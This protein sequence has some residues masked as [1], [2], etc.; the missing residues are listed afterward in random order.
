MAIG[1]KRR[2]AARRQLALAAELAESEGLLWLR[3]VIQFDR[4]VVAA[5]CGMP[6][7][8][9]DAA[10]EAIRGLAT[11]AILNER[12]EDILR[13]TIDPLAVWQTLPEE[14]R[15]LAEVELFWLFVGPLVMGR[16]VA[17]GNVDVIEVWLDQFAKHRDQ[18]INSQYWKEV[19]EAGRLVLRASPRDQVVGRI[20]DLPKDDVALRLLL[21]LALAQATGSVPGEV[22][23]A[24][25]VILGTLLDRARAASTMFDDF[26]SYLL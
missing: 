15:K 7:D 21:Y 5:S 14:R 1:I 19:F 26:V 22:L 17:H 8:S 18:F 20:N 25:G 6:Q 13:S 2:R 16:L 12:G 23:K 11:S 4:A 24:H 3:S 10:I 9:L